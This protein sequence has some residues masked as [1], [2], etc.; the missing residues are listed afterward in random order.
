MLYILF[1]IVKLMITKY[2]FSNQWVE[3]MNRALYL[4]LNCRVIFKATDEQWRTPI[5]VY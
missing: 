2:R 5:L 4:I 3:R 1:K